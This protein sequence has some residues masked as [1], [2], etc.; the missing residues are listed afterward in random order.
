M[1][2]RRAAAQ[3]D[4]ERERNLGKLGNVFD[5]VPLLVDRIAR[6]VDVVVR[7]LKRRFDREGRR[8]SD[9]GPA[10]VIRAGVAAFGFDGLDVGVL[11]DDFRQVGGEIGVDKVLD[12][13]DRR[14]RT[15]LDVL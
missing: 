8:D 9:L 15:R 4:R 2:D 7:I 6:R 3:L 1:D 13:A 5:R 14:R 10:R 11:G 12:D